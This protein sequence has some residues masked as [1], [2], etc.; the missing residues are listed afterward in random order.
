[1]FDAAIKQ[2]YHSNVFTKEQKQVW[3]EL[4]EEDQ[5][6]DIFKLYFT[7]KFDEDEKYAE[8]TTGSGGLQ[9]VNT[10]EDGE[11]DLDGDDE[12]VDYLYAL[13]LAATESNESINQ[14]NTKKGRP[15]PMSKLPMDK[16]FN[17]NKPSYL[18]SASKLPMR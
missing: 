9:G 14:V 2:I 18:P 7:A 16:L 15:W 10:V 4:D 3:E 8:A 1:M 12:V 13:K 5:T 17:P 11:E 6:F